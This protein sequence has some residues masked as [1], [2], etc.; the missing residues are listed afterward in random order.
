MVEMSRAS[1]V[2]SQPIIAEPENYKE[3][4]A[5]LAQQYERAERRAQQKLGDISIDAAQ[6][7]I[8]A[9]EARGMTGTH[10]PAD[11]THQHVATQ[12]ILSDPSSPDVAQMRGQLQQEMSKADA[13]FK[14]VIGR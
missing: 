9:R 14:G 11:A 4:K 1:N 6:K 10:I 12:Q 7:A 2:S 3:M 5:K 13:L 8:K